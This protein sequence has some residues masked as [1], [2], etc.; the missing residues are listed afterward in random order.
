MFCWVGGHVATGVPRALPTPP[1]PH[2][3][4]P[5]PLHPTLHWPVARCDTS[6]AAPH[7]RS[8]IACEEPARFWVRSEYRASSRAYVC[9]RKDRLFYFKS[10]SRRLT[11][12]LDIQLEGREPRHETDTRALDGEGRSVIESARARVCVV[13]T[14]SGAILTVSIKKIRFALSSFALCLSRA[15]YPARQKQARPSE[16][17]AHRK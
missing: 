12:E 6:S 17:K 13:A 14:G 3:R 9:G 7:T 8:S 4:A 15:G 16:N 2:A 5:Q 11:R 10:H 1:P